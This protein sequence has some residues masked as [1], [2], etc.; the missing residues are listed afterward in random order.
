MVNAAGIP[1]LFLMIRRYSRM[2]DSAKVNFSKKFGTFFNEFRSGS[3]CLFYFLFIIRRFAFLVIYL[4][5][6]SETVILCLLSLFS[7][8]VLGI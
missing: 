7:L 2:D 3:Y 1:A 4:T 5:V 6:K 8:S